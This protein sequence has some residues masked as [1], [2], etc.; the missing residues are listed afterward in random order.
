M[1]CEPE[2]DYSNRKITVNNT[3]LWD[4]ENP[5]FWG[6]YGPFRRWEE[7]EYDRKPWNGP[8]PRVKCSAR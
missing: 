4:V 7:Y 8:V 6:K 1:T 3:S 2:F 5:E